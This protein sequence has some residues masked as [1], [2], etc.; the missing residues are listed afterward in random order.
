MTLELKNLY[1]QKGKIVAQMQDVA[2]KLK[3]GKDLSTEEDAQFRAW[4]AELIATNGKIDI[5][6][7]SN[8]LD[9]EIRSIPGKQGNG[10][11]PEVEK[12][13]FSHAERSSLY[14]RAMYRGVEILSVEER[15]E[16]KKMQAENAAFTKMIYGGILNKEEREIMQ[17]LSERAQ[18]TTGSAG[19]YTIPQGFIAKIEAKLKY[20]SPFFAE[21]SV[22]LNPE[23]ESVFDVLRTATGNDLP[24]P[25][26]DDTAVT[27][28]LLAE[29]GDAFGNSTDLTFGQITLKAYKYNSKPMKVSNE[30]LTD[31]GL[32]LEGYIVNTLATRIARIAN[33]HLTTGDNSSKPQGI[34]TGATAGKTTAASAAMTFPE[35]LELIH[36]VDPSYRNSPSVRFMFHDN[37]L[38]YLKKLT[39]GSATNDSRPLWQPGYS[40]GAP[41]TIDGFR[42]L[43]NQDMASSL[44]TTNITMLFG[45]M[46]KYMVRIVSN[47]AVRQLT[48]RFADADQTAWLLFARL[49]GRYSN[50]SAIKKMT[51][52]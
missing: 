28:E 1:D 21:M 24:F 52:V 48:E 6:N 44:A 17:N 26:N 9:E 29:N 13:E 12:K 32:D 31:T 5:L 16:H 27:G 39:I 40:V 20:I 15:A 47:Y 4:D 38:L 2:R 41:D 43:I 19:G 14:K 34:V 25:T 45:D 7:K 22:G 30:L 8:A 36:S 42:Y 46:K 51:Q 50:T 33:T 37:I 11:G 18:A 23:A 49:D 3:E 35:V 10:Q